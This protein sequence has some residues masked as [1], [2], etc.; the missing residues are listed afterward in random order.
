LDAIEPAELV[1][2]IREIVERLMDRTA[3]D[4]AVE[5]EETMKQ[6]LLKFVGTYG[7]A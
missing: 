6:E 7:V 3:Y 1:K 2:I 5:R 4:A